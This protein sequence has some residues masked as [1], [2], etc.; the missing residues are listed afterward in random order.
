MRWRAG[1]GT[2]ATRTVTLGGLGVK[3]IV[4]QVWKRIDQDDVFGRAAQL[5]YYF[6]LA[7]CPLL[8]FL[9]TVLG[10]FFAAERDI[11]LRL[12]HYLGRVMPQP[13]FEL[14]RSTLDEI[15]ATTGTG[16]LTIG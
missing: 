1:I 12:I 8:I 16:K 4:I 5:S 7:L 10:Y 15:T 6:V 11:Y 14:L 2:Y 3:E 13:A 9:S